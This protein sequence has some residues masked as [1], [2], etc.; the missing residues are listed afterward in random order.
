V[1]GREY[2]ESEDYWDGNWLRV[3]AH[4]GAAGAEVSVSGGIL[5]LS[6]IVRWLAECQQ[7]RDTLVGSAKL[8]CIE[9]ELD[10][11][12]EMT[13][14]GQMSM[15]VNITPDH[16][17]QRHQ[18]RFDIDQT[19]LSNIIKGCGCSPRLPDEGPARLSSSQTPGR[20]S[21]LCRFV[22][23]RTDLLL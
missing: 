23:K 2:P 4:C 3:T 7:M 1:H 6:E 14:V 19:Y 9:P 12:L 21:T 17:N 8:D 11:V 16:L 20:I 15:T 10:V 18:L 5:H 22:L 13:T